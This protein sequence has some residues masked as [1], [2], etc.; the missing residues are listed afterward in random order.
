MMEEEKVK[1]TGKALQGEIPVEKR[2]FQMIAEKIGTIE[3]EVIAAVKKMRDDG[4]IRKFSAILRH[5]KAGYTKNAMV[6]WSVKA[7]D[8]EEKG[9][10]FSVSRQV[11]HCYERTPAF[12]G[13]YN[14]FTMVHAREGEDLLQV[15]KGL[16][17]ATGIDDFKV[18]ESIEEFKKSSMEYF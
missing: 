13:R 15:V 1:K 16:S 11:T 7:E 10:A 3:E 9:K 6:L 8:V 12:E 14:I 5:Q 17:R 18:L 2:P 4:R